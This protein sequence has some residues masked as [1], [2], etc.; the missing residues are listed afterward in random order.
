MKKDLDVEFSRTYGF[1][2]TA[3]TNVGNTVEGVLGVEGSLTD[4]KKDLDKEYERWK[5]KKRNLLGDREKLNSEISRLKASLMQQKE[6][7]EET[8]RVAGDV[9][10]LKAKNVKL[11]A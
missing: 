11:D 4:M 2:R 5:E 6:M 3:S 9:T 10:A 7:R 8:K 1:L